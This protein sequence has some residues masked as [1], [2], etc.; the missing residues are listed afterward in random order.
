M[1]N[2]NKCLHLLLIH[3]LFFLSKSHFHP[4]VLALYFLN[5]GK[6]DPSCVRQGLPGRGGERGS[7]GLSQNIPFPH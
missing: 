5:I 3:C 1:K 2:E 4:K 6:S 7:K